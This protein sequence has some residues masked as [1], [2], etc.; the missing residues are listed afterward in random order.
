MKEIG[1]LYICTGKYCIFWKKFYENAEKFLF[2]ELNHKKHY[3]VFTDAKHIAYESQSNVTKIFQEKLCW[4]YA[5]LY[6]FKMFLNVIYFLEKM[7]YLYFFNSNMKFVDFVGNDILPTELRPLVFAIHPGFFDKNINDFTYER[8]PKSLAYIPLNEGIG[9][10]GGGLNGGRTDRY[11]LMVK[12]LNLQIEQDER[13]NIIAVWH[14]ESYLNRY[15]Y[16]HDSEIL[17]LSP[18]YLY[19]DGWE[20]PFEKKIMVLD[21]SK[22]GG[23]NFLRGT[24]QS[25]LEKIITIFQ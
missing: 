12:V 25:L 10:Y 6:R 2:T 15:A 21:K 14:D 19:P 13:N 9:Y 24:N 17:K 16:E 7:D 11:L 22:Y 23:H 18:A 8:N 3:F 1:I 4:P 20:L 5:T